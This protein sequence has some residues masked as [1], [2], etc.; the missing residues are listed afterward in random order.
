MAIL[1]MISHGQG[2]RATAPT[3]NDALI[4]F[5]R[6]PKMMDWVDP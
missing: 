5:A 4:S 3:L 1:A 2:A 6:L